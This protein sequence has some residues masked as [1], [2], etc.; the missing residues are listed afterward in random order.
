[1]RLLRLLQEQGLE[2]ILTFLGHCLLGRHRHLKHRCSLI[3]QVHE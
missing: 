3:I 1:M 2:G